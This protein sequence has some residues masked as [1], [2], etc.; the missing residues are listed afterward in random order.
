M[1]FS[2]EPPEQQEAERKEAS[3]SGN[4][5]P[6]LASF[7]DWQQQNLRRWDIARSGRVLSMRSMVSLPVAFTTAFSVTTANRRSAKSRR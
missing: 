5:M 6:G 1:T 7:T 4:V 3:P 2:V